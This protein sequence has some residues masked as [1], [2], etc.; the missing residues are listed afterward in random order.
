[1]KYILGSYVLENVA[2]QVTHRPIR[3]SGSLLQM[4]VITH[5]V[6][7]KLRADTV[8]ELEAM[9]FELEAAL[10]AGSYL[11]AGLYHENNNPTA[12][13]MRTAAT[14][15]GIKLIDGPNYPVGQGAEYSV[16]RTV[17]FSIQA[18]IKNQNIDLVQF[19]ESISING[20]TRPSAWLIPADERIWPIR[21]RLP[22]VPYVITQSG[23]AETYSLAFAFPDP[24]F[25]EPDEVTKTNTGAEFAAGR[26]AT[27]KWAWSYR[28]TSIQNPSGIF[29]TD[30][31]GFR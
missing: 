20:G 29:P 12:H 31:R 4:M 1:M 18:E 8:S 10:A 9:I 16:F 27:R 24:L 2:L 26:Q 21:Q 3:L 11:A 6:T 19:T 22:R 23:T 28:S 5:A 7:G 13:V 25:G 14:L 17:Q 15:D 30:R